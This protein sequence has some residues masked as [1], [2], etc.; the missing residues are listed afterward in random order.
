M[1]SDGRLVLFW[2]WS[3]S[4]GPCEVGIFDSFKVFLM[5][6]QAGNKRTSSLSYVWLI[7]AFAEN[8]IYSITDL[9]KSFLSL[10]WT[11]MCFNVFVGCIAVDTQ[12]VSGR[13][14]LFCSAPSS[15][16]WWQPCLW[17]KFLLVFFFV[18]MWFIKKFWDEDWR[19]KNQS[20]DILPW[21]QL[22]V[23]IK[24]DDTS[25]DQVD[26]FQCLGVTLA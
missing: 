5:F 6:F 25:L 3:V 16:K 13:L 8:V 26:R 19:A 2:G 4:I 18:C 11:W 17:M 9:C 12:Y 10:W 24:L 1:I 14:A 23:G 20:Y 7:A 22:Q 15:T 21:D